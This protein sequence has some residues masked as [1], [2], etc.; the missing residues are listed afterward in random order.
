M[1]GFSLLLHVAVIASIQFKAPDLSRFRDQLPSLEVVLVNA[2]TETMPLAPQVLAQANLDRGGN[3]DAKQQLKS[4]LPVPKQSKKLPA[5]IDDEVAQKQ[6]KVKELEKQVQQVLTQADTTT[7][8]ASKPATPEVAQQTKN[9][10]GLQLSARDMV[11][12]SLADVARLEAKLD[13][14][15]IIYQE[16]PKRQF[17]GAVAKEYRFASYVDA[18]RQKVER[19]GNN[20]YPEEAKLQKLYG[21]LVMTVAINADGSVEKIEINHSSG[22]KILDDAA[23][24]IVTNAAPY[25]AFPAEIRKDTD[26]LEIS[27]TWTFTREDMLS[28]N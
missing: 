17:I 4:P 14:E 15:Q 27:R 1:L 8:P 3:T 12:K 19:W 20:N 28:A 9:T 5:K 13:K 16:R 11:S 23:R 25:A 18:W 22:S 7:T 2:K 24:N 21:K 6:R 10:S 26:I